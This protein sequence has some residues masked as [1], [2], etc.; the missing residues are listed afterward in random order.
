MA[1]QS[2]YSNLDIV[3]KI[4]CRIETMHEKGTGVLVA[5]GHNELLYL[6]T[7][8][9]C[10]LGSNFDQQL[11]RSSVKILI[12]GDTKEDFMPITL[13][14]SDEILFPEEEHIDCAVIVLNDLPDL[15]IPLV[16]ILNTQYTV[17][18]C[19]FRGYPQAYGNIKA[20]PIKVNYVDNNVVTTNT[21]LYS[22]D[23]EPLYNC[24]G[25]SGSGVFVEVDG[26]VFLA[27]LIYE[28]E[29]PFQ[30]FKVC[31][32]SFLNELLFSHNYPEIAFQTL[33]LNETITKDIQIL[34]GKSSLVLDGI[35]HKLGNELFLDRKIIDEKF[36]QKFAVN[37]LVIIKGL[38]GVGKTVFARAVIQKLQDAD[39]YPLVFK[40]DSFGK[41]SIDDVFGYLNNTLND[42]F[43]QIGQSQQIIILIDS[44]EKLLETDSYEALKEFLRICRRFENIKIIITCRA[45]AYQQLIFQL[46]YEFPKYDFIDVPLLDDTELKQ[47]EAKFP[48]LKNLSH[49]KSF[50]PILQRPFYLNLVILHIQLFKGNEEITERE[51]RKVIWDEVISKRNSERGR[52][53]EEIALARAT[54]MSLYARVEGLDSLIVSQLLND[55]II[56]AEENLS[57]SFSPSHDIYEDVALIRVVER[58]YQEKQNT[59]DFFVRFGKEPAKRRAFR[60]W[61]NEY[62]VDASPNLITFVS[63]IFDAREVEQYWKDEVIIAILKSEYCQIFFDSYEEILRGDY[64]ALLLRFI[65]LLRTSCQEPDEQLIQSLRSQNQNNI[66]QWLYL[67]PVGPGWGVVISFIHKYFDDLEDHKSLILRLL[68]KNW[69][70]KLRPDQKL[71]S[72]ASSAGQLLFNI[73]D[74][75]KYHYS[76]RNSQ[77]LSKKD[78][79]E[80]IKVIFKLSSIFKNE[81]RELIIK[82]ESF[83]VKETG[84]YHL[85]DF[86]QEVIEYTLSGLENREICQELPEL[87][88]QVAIRNWLKTEAV[89]ARYY[90]PINS[91][92]DFGITDKL[93]LGY[94]PAGIYKTPAR[95]LLFYHPKMALKLIVLVLNHATEAYSKSER[96]I[97]TG[98]TQVEIENKD[99]SIINQ[100]G[101][102]VIWAMYRGLVEVTPHLLQSLLMSLESW[103][104]ELCQIQDEW[105]HKLIEYTFDYL[106]KNSTSVATT[107]VLA[108]VATAYPRQ[109]GKL[110][111]PILK[112]KEFY[113]WDLH[114]CAVEHSSLAPY[115]Q[116]I[117][118][119]Q[120]ERFNANKLPHRK[121]N[122]E[123]LITNLQVG[124]YWEE[125]NQIIDNFQN[126]VDPEDK[127]WKLALNSMDI[128]KYEVDN[129]IEPPEKNQIPVKPKINEDLRE[130]VEESQQDFE[131]INKASG[132]W[133][134][135]KKVFDGEND[136]EISSEKWKTEYQNYLEIKDIEHDITRLFGDPTYL[137]AI[138]IKFF[139]TDLSKE[140]LDW[141]IYVLLQVLM[142]RIVNNI[143]QDHLAITTPFFEP[144]I[145]T[146]PLILSLEI[147]DETRHQT[148]E[149][150]FLSLL[151]LITHEMEYPFGGIR[152]KLWEID[153]DFANACFA[154]MIE[155]AKLYKQK[156][157]YSFPPS[158]EEEIRYFEEFFSEEQKL[159]KRVCENQIELNIENLSFETHSHWFLVFAAL[160][161]P[162]NS[163]NG[164][165][166]SFTKQIFA[167]LFKKLTEDRRSLNHDIS[168]Y[169][170]TS[171]KYQEYFARFLLEQSPSEAK[172]L[173][174]EI[175]DYVYRQ[176][177]R[178]KYEAVEFVE[179]ILERLIL[180]EDQLHS[181]NLWNLWEELE[182]KIRKS[183]KTY[184]ISYLFLSLRWWNSDA[185]DWPPL[186]GKKSYFKG[187]II[188]LGHFDLKSV[189]KLLAGIGTEKFLPEGLIW[190]K[191]VLAN[192]PDTLKELNDSD[193]FFY[194]EKLIQRTYYKHLGDIKSDNILKESLL[195]LL[196]SLV[197]LDS[198]IA[199]I[200]RERV[201]SLSTGQKW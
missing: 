58:F 178:H 123:T 124:G 40:A 71:P 148:K 153:N 101:N 20:I 21:A 139:H 10:L 70:R 48:S 96:G 198:S 50:I 195:F 19:F 75:E 140:N 34:R 82:A 165:H 95:F 73:I 83:S 47:V 200:I 119:A 86:Y 104:L 138:G 127:L 118:F 39:F 60:L 89:K 13:K 183:E 32:F 100:K 160:I 9:H 27:G 109:I 175:L 57:E 76:S 199:F 144:A 38:A 125:I 18:D 33:P 81:V 156:W 113:R 2:T 98:I 171:H 181:G 90:S 170:T 107:A 24:Q 29:E 169:L 155:Y 55:N 130:I 201:I 115:E 114:R 176:S 103:M 158:S 147:D 46:H 142:E 159:V 99:D 14:D 189:A 30:R 17:N 53:F 11:D 97:R 78:L 146:V 74:E 141:C 135:A 102:S 94:S 23:S 133:N 173:F 65:H 166:I 150:I 5:Y 143:R 151:H 68:T 1:I 72:E 110:C 180:E 8:K 197:N 16:E 193:T 111:F 7:A 164:L 172:T 196:D 154:G 84:N 43:V 64:F 190:A 132:T 129:S 116:D 136:V 152:N 37:K 66:Y 161:I 25:F 63:E 67:K 93:R 22:I 26:R 61:L 192:N 120:E 15:D 149:V 36:F 54:S 59:P 162:F 88:C 77:S 187:L 188:G 121:H 51:F 122:L 69:S 56:M 185:T 191:I 117:P 186:Q 128:R 168:A 12:P 106:L 134:W 28:L 3:N 194:C 179:R 80:A 41:D 145:Q 126:T 52:V 31:D 35:F 4:T 105:A 79:K 45:Y 137:A 157:R 85:R 6:I 87:V 62:L 49:N 174:S 112:V 108:S 167:L 177:D 182:S 163:S 184:F 131:L 91:E 42:I 92:N 44:L